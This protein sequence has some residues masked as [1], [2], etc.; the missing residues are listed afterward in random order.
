MNKQVG[1][2]RK[3]GGRE[4]IPQAL[5]AKVGYTLQIQASKARD[6]RGGH[7]EGRGGDLGALLQFQELE[8]GEVMEDE[9]EPYVC[10]PIAPNQVQRANSV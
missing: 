9:R 6:W 4:R 8:V 5:V 7:L 2:G 1:R 3:R 10:D